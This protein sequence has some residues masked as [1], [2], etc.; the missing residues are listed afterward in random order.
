VL[1]GDNH[2]YQYLNKQ[3]TI[4]YSSSLIQQNFGEDL[5]YHGI[6]KWNI[7]NHSSEFIKV[8]NKY[9]YYVL[10]INNGKITEKLTNISKSPRI[11]FVI[12]NTNQIEL[13][14]II[15]YLNANYD[16]QQILKE[17][18]D[19]NINYETK[20]VVEKLNSSIDQNELIIKYFDGKNI[21]KDDVKKILEINNELNKDIIKHES[22]R[23]FRWNLISLKFSN[24]FSYGE[25][26][27]IN[28]KRKHGVIGILAPNYYGKSSILDIILYVLFDKCSRGNI[29]DIMNIF[30]NDFMCKLKIGIGSYTYIIKKSGKRN[31]DSV[32]SRVDFY[33]VIKDNIENLNGDDRRGTCENISTIFGEYTE[34]TYTTISL[35]NSNNNFI[36]MSQMTRKKFLNELLNIDIFDKL[37][38]IAQDK[39]K[40]LLIEINLL[41]IGDDVNTLTTSKDSFKHQ[42]SDIGIEIDE[43]TRKISSICNMIETKR[44]E[45]VPI[46]NNLKSSI[47][48]LNIKKD[49]L[50]KI[51]KEIKTQ[52]YENNCDKENINCRIKKIVLIDESII[53]EKHQKIINSNKELSSKLHNDI[54]EL[55][56]HIELDVVEY[57]QEELILEKETT[58]K[59]YEKN[60]TLILKLNESNKEFNDVINSYNELVSNIYSKIEVL[61]LNRKSIIKLDEDIDSLCDMSGKYKNDIETLKD[62]IREIDE[63]LNKFHDEYETLDIKISEY[64][65]IDQLVDEKQGYEKEIVEIDCEINKVSLQILNGEKILEQLKNHKFNPECEYC[66]QNPFVMNAY[67]IRD[68]SLPAMI[69]EF[70]KLEFNKQQISNKIDYTIDEK[71]KIYLSLLEKKKIVH[72]QLNNKN[73]EK[74]KNNMKL[75]KLLNNLLDIERKYKIAIDNE[76][77]IKFNNVINQDIKKL[78]E[79]LDVLKHNYTQYNKNN[80]KIMKLNKLKEQYNKKLDE[81]EINMEKCSK[82]KIIIENNK[83][84]RDDIDKIKKELSDIDNF[85]DIEYENYNKNKKEKDVLNMSLIKIDEK[86]LSNKE[87][88]IGVSMELKDIENEILK[89]ELN[90]KNKIFNKRIENAIDEME[91]EKNK[92]QKE[93]TAL[94]EGKMFLRIKLVSLEEKMERNYKNN[95]LLEEKQT[96]IELYKRYIESIQ[97]DGIPY[98]LLQEYIPILEQEVNKILLSFVNFRVKMKVSNTNVDVLLEREEKT[99]V[100]QLSSGFEKFVINLSLR[101]ALTNLSKKCKPNFIAIDEGWGAFDHTNINNV[102]EIF[103]YMRNWYDKVIIIS[104]IEELKGNIDEIIEIRKE[105]IESKVIS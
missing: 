43:I 81:L 72:E 33:R 19:N 41:K 79:E 35:Q 42:I 64:D 10:H 52:E 54:N 67:E 101:I 14:N 23:N 68:K 60:N 76:E 48:S 9:G 38:E 11:H 58:L 69:D 50:L 98:M 104:H 62:D 28:F 32:K 24:L 56:I 70:N 36:D 57:N 96:E 65:G 40:E 78:K 103:D 5:T 27:Y 89:V 86:I 47:V 90:E 88:L 4:A 97:V 105:G 7:I 74:T 66:V 18:I 61:I 45:L 20:E 77:N 29:R 17:Y 63:L 6:I 102:G 80:D 71:Y 26:N 37:L 92:L 59:N 51:E 34:F 100:A 73:D 53:N 99:Y 22:N 82:N 91:V 93:L 2:K 13:N 55:S 16:V 83:K 31:K 25:D 15:N 8:Y 39:K 85:I 49:K 21:K 12:R 44:K 30:K 94:N 1:L 84:S 75:D 87:R 46:D 95:Q 3:K